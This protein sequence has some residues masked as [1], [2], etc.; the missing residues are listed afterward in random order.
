MAPL[1]SRQRTIR[2]RAAAF[3]LHAQ[4]KTSTSAATA[5][6]MA[7]FETQVDPDRVL[8]PEERAR[9]AEYARKSYF[10]SLALKASRAR[11]SRLPA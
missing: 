7:R 5:A 6:S 10:T 1:D 2:A 3:A 8:T 9:R 4:G 11:S